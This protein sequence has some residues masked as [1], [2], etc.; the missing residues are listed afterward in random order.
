VRRTRNSIKA[1]PLAWGIALGV[2]VMGTAPG[3]ANDSSAVL[4]AGGLVLTS[5]AGI[6]MR[7]E[8]LKISVKA[9]EVA[10]E[11]FNDTDKPITTLVA[12]P[13][14]VLRGTDALMDVG[15][16]RENDPT[17]F[18]GFSITVDG[19]PVEPKLEQRARILGL[20][21]TDRLKAD[22]IPLNP[23]VQRDTRERLAKLPAD[24]RR[25]YV[26]HGLASFTGNEVDSLEWDVATTFYWLQT[27]PPKKPVKITHRYTPVVGTGLFTESNL[28]PG[29]DT[30]AFLRTYC[31]DR[32]T[33][34]GIR[35]ALATRKQARPTESPMLFESRIG[36]VLSTGANWA[37]PI[38]DFRLTIEKPKPDS[39]M[40]F[41][42]PGKLTKTSPT[43]FQ[44][45]AKDFL[46]TG[47]LSI[48]FVNP[49]AP[50]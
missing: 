24:K 41:C 48:V 49:T 25:F 6:L 1:L 23:F 10:Y 42:F 20:D 26:E 36:Y 16:P 29:P 12:F 4:S 13:L 31:I 22:G 2:A 50:D 27:F 30:S 18:V 14:P 39:I 7:S 43:T 33:E 38:G 15:L 44:F 45:T 35:K 47:D 17:N 28:A 5:N 8:D 37:G 32:D 21:I 11:F 46:P 9:V 19:K 34:N 40:S 3:Q